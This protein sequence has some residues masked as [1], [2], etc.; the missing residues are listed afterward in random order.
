LGV[1]GFPDVSFTVELQYVDASGAT[2]TLTTQTAI[3]GD[4]EAEEF[5]LGYFSFSNLEAGT[6]TLMQIVPEGYVVAGRLPVVGSVDGVEE[7]DPPVDGTTITGIDIAL[8]SASATGYIFFS[9]L[10]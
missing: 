5:G 3:A 2:V 7:G 6:Y 8:E 10:A 1:E 9:V 4:P